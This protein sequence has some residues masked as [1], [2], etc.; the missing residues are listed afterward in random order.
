[1]VQVAAFSSPERSLALVQRL[2]RSG[3]PAFEVATDMGARGLL[4]FVRVG[5]YKTSAEADDARI[6]AE[7][8]IPEMEG[9]FVRNVA[10]APK[11]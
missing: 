2:T 4:Y 6:T 3:L 9:M 7:Q 8:A 1:V 11:L 10:P 5:P